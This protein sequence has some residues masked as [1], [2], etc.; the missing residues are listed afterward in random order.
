MI[1]EL[2]RRRG[3]SAIHRAPAHPKPRPGSAQ[4]GPLSAKTRIQVRQALTTPRA[5]TKL[6]VG[7]PDDAYEREADNVA[8][9]VMRVP[10]A[11]VQQGHVP[12]LGADLGAVRVHADANAAT[13]A[14]AV[15]ARAFTLGPDIVFANGAYA[16]GT[17]D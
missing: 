14:Q 16:P 5:Q 10:D 8:D 2:L 1:H 11:A 13:A 9:A 12:R 3:S 6:T 17:S 15:S 4:I 7:P